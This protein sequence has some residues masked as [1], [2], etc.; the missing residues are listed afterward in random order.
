M[1][2]KEVK[3]PNF[4]NDLRSLA[5][6]EQFLAAASRGVAPIIVEMLERPPPD[7]NF[8]VTDERGFTALHLAVM[9]GFH[10]IVEVLLEDPRINV[11]ALDKMS[12]HAIQLAWIAERPDIASYLLNAVVQRLTF[13]QS[14]IGNEIFLRMLFSS[15]TDILGSYQDLSS[16]DNYKMT[17]SSLNINYFISTPPT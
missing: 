8:N 14:S 6:E 13:D 4:I 12:R 9:R 3:L 11:N 1:S 17:Q 7:F 2:K 15:R 10:F 5:P 16:L